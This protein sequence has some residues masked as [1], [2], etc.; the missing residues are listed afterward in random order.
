MAIIVCS[1]L[2]CKEEIQGTLPWEKNGRVHLGKGNKKFSVK[3]EE[4][5]QISHS[6]YYNIM[7]QAVS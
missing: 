6:N 2:G 7:C 4:S 5:L 3:L 1:Q